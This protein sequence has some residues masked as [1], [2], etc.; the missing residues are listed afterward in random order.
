MAFAT[1]PDDGIRIYYEVEGDGP[2]LVIHSG[3]TE[4]ILNWR[5]NGYVDALR[6]AYRL[7]LLDPR[8]HGRSDKPHDPQQYRLS[9]MAA[10]VVNILDELS[11][12]R[13]H[14]LGYSLGAGVGCL[15]VHSAPDRFLSL[16]AGGGALY[17][18]V[19]FV[20]NFLPVFR[21]GPEALV[22]ALDQPPGTLPDSRR[23]Q[24]L[25]TDT[26]AIA[27]LI[28]AHSEPFSLEPLLPDISVPSLIYVGEEDVLYPEV[29]RA[30]DLLPNARF[31]T[32]PGL[33]HF[34]A[35]SRADLVLPHV[36]AFLSDITHGH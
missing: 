13:A 21:Q 17:L 19:P 5:V 27:A 30:A 7:V 20:V 34:Q 12:E 6:D 26:E 24:L 28:T 10:D 8:G 1:N 31:V 4:G 2:P 32:L 3:L 15:A 35:A 36:T 23:T 9:L 29:R 14:Y 25:D 18:P 16:I 22:A 11:I 33:D